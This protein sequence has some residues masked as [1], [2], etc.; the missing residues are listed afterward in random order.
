M[1]V[2][3]GVTPGEVVP[4]VTYRPDGTDGYDDLA[5]SVVVVRLLGVDVPVA[6]LED[7]IRSKEAAGR[8]KDIAVLPILIEHSR[9]V[10]AVTHA[11]GDRRAQLGPT[12]PHPRAYV[13]SIT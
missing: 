10:G 3:V 8:A 9:A 13:K 2:D 6:S 12:C 11:A 5:R 7:I 4:G 1:W